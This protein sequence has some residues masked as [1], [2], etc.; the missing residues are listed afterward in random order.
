MHFTATSIRRIEGDYLVSENDASI[1]RI[2]ED[3]SVSENDIIF[4]I[5]NFFEIGN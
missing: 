3:K 1:R 5:P 4:P 2:E